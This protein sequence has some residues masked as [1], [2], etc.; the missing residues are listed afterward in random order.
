LYQAKAFGALAPPTF[1]TGLKQERSAFEENL[2][3]LYVG[4][5]SLNINDGLQSLGLPAPLMHEQV[6]SR[7]VFPIVLALSLNTRRYT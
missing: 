5:R 3:W 6:A 2:S 1:T 7:W 4:M